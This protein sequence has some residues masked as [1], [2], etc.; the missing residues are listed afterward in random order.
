MTNHLP[1]SGFDVDPAIARKAKHLLR[2]ADLRDCLEEFVAEQ[3]SIIRD[4]SPN[5]QASR[6]SAYH[7]QRGAEKFIEWLEGT[8]NHAG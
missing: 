1:P 5:D 2:S 6:E 8:A 7:T 4:S 3:F